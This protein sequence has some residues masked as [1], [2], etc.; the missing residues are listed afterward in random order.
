MK[1]AVTIQDIA[2][3]LNLSRNTVAKALNGKYVPD[4]TREKILKKAIELNYKSYSALNSNLDSKKKYRL[5]LVSGKP[6]ININFFIPIIKGIEN[7]CYQCDYELV[8][9]IFNNDKNNFEELASYVKSINPDGIIGI[10]FFDIEIINKLKKLNIPLC[11]YDFDSMGI[12]GN[13]NLDVIL[14]SSKEP[15]SKIVKMINQKYGIKKFCFVGDCTHCLSFKH[16]Y[17]GMLET[18]YMLDIEHNKSFDILRTDNFDYGNP[19]AILSEIIKLKRRPDCYI[20]ANDFIARNTVNALKLLGVNVPE[21]ALV[22][23]YD[24]VVE[25]KHSVPGITTFDVNK[26]YI[27][28]ETVKTIVQRIEQKDGP[29]K[30]ILINPTLFI[31]DSTLKPNKK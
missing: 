3:Q 13:E 1:K 24:N 9:Y 4:K 18:L 2:D 19:Q 5:L 31:R 10:E 6:L 29:T 22:V 27:G 21:K 15:V 16:R 25:S 14:A 30:I 23:G 12:D 26:E 8:Q 17:I 11:F 20:C 28:I 7:Y